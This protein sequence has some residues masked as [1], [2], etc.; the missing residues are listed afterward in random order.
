MTDASLVKVT[1]SLGALFILE[2]RWS[3]LYTNSKTV[4]TL[5]GSNERSIL[6]FAGSNTE[7][8]GSQR[9]GIKRHKVERQAKKK[10]QPMPIG[11]KWHW[12]GED[13]PLAWDPGP[14]GA[15]VCKDGLPLVLGC[16]AWWHDLVRC[17]LL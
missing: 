6:L 14:L 10:K 2:I 17:F 11:A 8:E 5:S 12:K 15:S 13:M 16:A 1:L 9:K 4:T 3:V 7:K